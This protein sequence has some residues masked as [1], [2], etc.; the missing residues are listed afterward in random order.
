M[1]LKPCLTCGAPTRTGSRCRKCAS[2]N[3]RPYVTPAWRRISKAVTTSDGA[4][5]EC[6][7]TYRLQAHHDIP[8][9]EGGPD[10]RHNLVTLCGSC[11]SRLEAQHRS[12]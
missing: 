5:T 11:H 6:G 12:R 1:A 9:A 8:R 7:S 2:V 10:T 4:C 3:H